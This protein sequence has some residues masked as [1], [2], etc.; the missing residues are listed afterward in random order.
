MKLSGKIYLKIII[1]DTKKQGFALSLEKIFFE[2]SQE[3]SHIVSLPNPTNLGLKVS[4]YLDITCKN[5]EIFN[6]CILYNV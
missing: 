4:K 5:Q 6:F 3:G 2:K 1:K